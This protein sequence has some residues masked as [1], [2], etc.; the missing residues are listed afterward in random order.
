[1]DANKKLPQCLL[2]L[3]FSFFFAFFSTS[4]K[5]DGVEEYSFRNNFDK[6]VELFIFTNS[7]ILK[8]S[9]YEVYHIISGEKISFVSLKS[10]D[11]YGYGM[12]FFC[13]QIDSAKL[14]IEGESDYLVIWVN[15]EE[16]IYKTENVLRWNFFCEWIETI[17]HS[18][19]HVE[20]TYVLE[21]QGD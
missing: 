8:E 9:V 1:M 21:K 19:S 15:S 18:S 2:I 3:G 10:A 11:R 16:P 12:G 13:T 6:E 5:Q 20:Y 4:C 7:D 14:K 17:H